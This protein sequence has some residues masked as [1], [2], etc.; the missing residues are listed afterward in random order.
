MGCLYL[1]YKPQTYLSEGS[2]T[3][4]VF[5]FVSGKW[6]DRLRFA[7]ATARPTQSRLI[8]GAEGELQRLTVQRNSLVVQ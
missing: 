5:S 1:N 6:P 7:T 2:A 4:Y 3:M 8:V